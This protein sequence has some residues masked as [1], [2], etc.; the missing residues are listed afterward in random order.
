MKKMNL[1]FALIV[2]TFSLAQAATPVLEMRTTT[3]S[4]SLAQDVIV[5]TDGT[6]TETHRKSAYPNDAL[7]PTTVIA[8]LAQTEVMDIEN[9]INAIQEAPLV[10]Q[11][12]GQVPVPG[13]GA[14]TNYILTHTNGQTF[15]FAQ[16]LLGVPWGLSNIQGHELVVFSNRFKAN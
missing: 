7:T 5:Y 8:N 2:S 10:N 6:V 4:N 13:F 15:V 3:H 11:N 1:I 16:N 14:V 12:P 9:S